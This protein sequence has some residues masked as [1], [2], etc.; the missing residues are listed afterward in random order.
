MAGELLF[1]VEKSLRRNEE[2]RAAFLTELATTLGKEESKKVIS[3]AR[4]IYNAN[5]LIRQ[6]LKV[7]WIALLIVGMWFVYGI[8][9]QWGWA[10]FVSLL[11]A[12]F[13]VGA[14]LELASLLLV[15]WVKG[16]LNARFTS[17]D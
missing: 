8:F 6:V 16:K 14:G 13:V 2:Q 7:I 4:R 5:R 9:A 10:T 12:A 15:S 3:T 17:R 11:A 1:Y